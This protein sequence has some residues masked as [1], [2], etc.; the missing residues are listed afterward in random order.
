MMMGKQDTQSC[1]FSYSVDLEK[2]VRPENPLRQ[3]QQQVDFGWV[4][5]EVNHLYGH[6]GNVSVDPEVILKMLFL[7]FWDNIKSERE[8]MRIIPERLDYLW[9]LG[10]GLDQEIPDHSVLSKARGRWG[11]AVFE[12]FFVKT[13]EQAVRLG[14]VS[15]EKIHVDAS[16]VQANASNKKI[17]HGPPELI[18]ALRAAYGAQE[19]KLS[20]RRSNSRREPKYERTLNTTDPDAPLVAHR[21]GGA[22]GQAR[23]R[24]KHHRVL[25][26]RCGVITAVATT[27]GHV[28]EGSCLLELTEQH[29]TQTGREAKTVVADSEYGTVENFRALQQKGMSTHMGALRGHG[30]GQEKG[31]F[32]VTEFRYDPQRDT[33]E[34][35]AG[36]TLTRRGFRKKENGWLY[37]VS[38]KIC[39][40]CPLRNRCIRSDKAHY[41]RMVVRYIGQEWVERGWQ[42]SASPAARADRRRRMSLVEGSFGQAT[43]NHHF[44]RARWRRLWR[45]QIQDWLIATA[46]NI[47]KI[48]GVIAR[49]F[50]VAV[51][52]VTGTAFSALKSSLRVFG[53]SRGTHF[54]ENWA[55]VTS[56]PVLG[57]L[58]LPRLITIV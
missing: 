51:A 54:G 1:L 2:R 50:A 31:I 49:P 47:K 57:L 14:L 28:N 11:R 46:Q 36:Q 40:A 5:Q 24:Y 26:D 25:D 43:L 33:Y 45:Q 18:A 19:R 12:R 21:K 15:G 3:I 30:Q 29:Q 16:L 6:N 52:A 34:C 8:L 42:Q 7:L 38:S 23:A 39:R 35:P 22:H 27:P 13:V 53:S 37:R 20:S 55:A 44:K 9:F 17:V 32:S 58:S 41:S 56:K 10:Y 4:C 48:V